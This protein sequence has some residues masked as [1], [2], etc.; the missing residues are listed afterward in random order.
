MLTSKS[1]KIDRISVV[2]PTM[3]YTFLADIEGLSEKRKKSLIDYCLYCISR[4]YLDQE[5]GFVK[6]MNNGFRDSSY[7]KTLLD[8]SKIFIDAGNVN[9]IKS[10]RISKAIVEAGM[11]ISA[12]PIKKSTG[13]FSDGAVVNDPSYLDELGVQ[14]EMNDD[15]YHVYCDQE[16]YI[17]KRAYHNLSK[18][19]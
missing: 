10:R 9:K 2:S 18:I 8:P 3:P 4:I 15:N 6:D 14:Y 1:D 17:L 13:L 5:F 7:V 11:L 19:R 16:E 12:Y